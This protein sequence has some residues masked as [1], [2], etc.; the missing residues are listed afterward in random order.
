MAKADQQSTSITWTWIR[1]IHPI[2]LEI[3][4]SP[5]YCG[6]W[7]VEQIANCRVRWRAKAKRSPNAPLDNFWQG[8]APSI[9]FAECTATKLVPAPP[10]T[11]VGLVSITL[12]GLAV[13]R[14][15]IA[16]HDRLTVSPSV[17]NRIEP[18]PPVGTA[19]AKRSMTTK[20]WIEAEIRQMK[21]DGEI[22]A[23]ITDFAMVLETRME[24]AAGLNRSIRPVS[25]RHI[26][27]QLPLWGF[28][29]IDRI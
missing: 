18:S 27:N 29:P 9:D 10:G 15:D 14:E 20:S 28:W 8:S 22:P 24:T 23:K 25:W 12:L 13:V 26:K 19:P 11:V 6:P 4:G 3:C 2:V 7:L 17:E 5:Q 16:I 21:A 1:D